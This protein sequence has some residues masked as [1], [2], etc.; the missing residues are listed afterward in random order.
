MFSSVEELISSL[1]NLERIEPRQDLEM[2]NR[3]QNLLDE[4]SPL[5]NLNSEI[6][7]RFLSEH[8]DAVPLLAMSCGLGQEQLKNQLKF[9]FNTS[10]WTLLARSKPT[11]LVEYF[12]TE[13]SLLKQLNME[14][15][16]KWTFSEVLV[17]RH[18]WSRKSGSA[19]VGRGREIEDAVEL[20]VR[21][22]GLH[23]IMRTRF[24]GRGEE[25][26]P[27]DLAIPAGMEQ[28]QIVIGM[29]GFNSTGSKLTDAVTEIEKMAAVRRPSQYV[30]AVIDGIGWLNRQAD[31]HR[32]YHLASS[33]RIDGL[34]TLQTMADLRDSV[35]EA[36]HRLKLLG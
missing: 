35:I 18:L 17:E 6:L 23:Y 14:M 15:N 9:K 27:C 26:A 24:T 1:S 34:F 20:I 33:H 11:E 4:L 30:F 28:A 16:K 32:I 2:A 12:D 31:L 3:I 19:S 25:T 5:K 22:L 29:K 7:I 21:Q 13:Y 8:P 10:S 36:A